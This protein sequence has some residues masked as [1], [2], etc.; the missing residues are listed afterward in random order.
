MDE[1]RIPAEVVLTEPTD[2]GRVA[3]ALARLGLRVLHVATTVS[4]EGTRDQ[5]ESA[6]GVAFV[7]QTSAVQQELG[8]RVGFLH[9]DPASI[10]VPDDLAGLVADVAFVEPPQLH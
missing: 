3:R 1:Q 8:K 9:A 6:F 4:V 10:V 7:R 5:W 2:V